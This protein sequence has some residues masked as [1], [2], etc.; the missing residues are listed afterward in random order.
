LGFA[1][2]DESD[3]ADDNDAVEVLVK[4]E[5]FELV[6]DGGAVAE[7]GDCMAD[8]EADAIGMDESQSRRSVIA[9]DRVR[10]ESDGV[11]T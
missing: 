9:M 11:A 2:A 7:D 6:S 3:D 4:M 5:E 8:G 10:G 1:D